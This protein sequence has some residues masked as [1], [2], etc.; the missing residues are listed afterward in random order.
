MSK[1][2]D[3]DGIILILEKKSTD[4]KKAFKLPRIPACK[5][6]SDKCKAALR[7]RLLL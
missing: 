2:F 5:E 3:T 7:T 1:L 6:F 4:N